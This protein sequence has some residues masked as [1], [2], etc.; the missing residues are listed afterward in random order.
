MTPYVPLLMP[1][2]QK[3]LLDPLPEVR[4]TAAR[5]MGSLLK[6]MGA[7]A[8]G[9]LLPWLLATLRSEGSSV[10]RSGAAQV[11]G[12]GGYSPDLSTHKVSMLSSLVKSA[13]CFRLAVRWLPLRTSSVAASAA[14][15]HALIRLLLRLRA[16]RPPPQGLAEVLSVLGEEHLAQLLPELFASA[17]SKN[18]FVREGHLTLFRY[19]P[20]TME[21]AFQEHLGEVLPLILDGL[22]DEVRRSGT[23]GGSACVRIGVHAACSCAGKAVRLGCLW[24]SGVCDCFHTN[25][26]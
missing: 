17:T 21:Q 5:A 3:A 23:A 25:R 2:L 15:G 24:L 19:L 13:S 9:D 22:S 18:P 11:R 7:A 16:V 1:E 20:L 4:A 26:A 8:L 12:L 10:E 14:V 6:G